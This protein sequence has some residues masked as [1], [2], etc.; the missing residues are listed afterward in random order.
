M[1]R[2]GSF[3]NDRLGWESHVAPFA[4]KPLPGNL[5]WTFSLGSLCALLF[6]VQVIT[7]IVL[8]AYYN[9]SPD[10][11]YRSI[12]YIM[13]EVAAGDILRSLHHWAGA[14][15]VIAVALHLLSSLYYGAYKAPREV[16][17]IFGV[18]LFLLVLGFGFTGYLLPWDQKAYWATVV[19][20]NVAKDIP[21][22]GS[23]VFGLLRGGPEVSGLTLTRFY[24]IHILVLPLFTALFIGLHIYLIR[25]HDIAGHW[26]PDHPKKEKT[27]RFFPEHLLKSAIVFWLV[28]GALLVMAIYIKPPREEIAMT[29]DP[30]Y[31]PRPEWYY[32]WLFK[33]LT[34]FEGRAEI[35]GSVVVPFRRSGPVVRPALFV[36]VSVAGSCRQADRHGRRG[37]DRSRN[38]VS[39][40]RRNCGFQAIR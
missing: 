17:W 11:A 15:M 22:I 18:G 32:M 39:F 12:D 13:N 4:G 35:I 38:R 30:T 36:P 2:L 24:T 37:I 27:S 21:L 33:L 16:T 19:G 10:H 28:F 34:F 25:I 3:L 40:H 14:A 5:D 9:P 26:N 31:L 1:S 6:A 20:T 23:Y 8:A 29:P 7:G